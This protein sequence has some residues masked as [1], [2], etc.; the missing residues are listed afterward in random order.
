MGGKLK[1]WPGAASHRHLCWLLLKLRVSVLKSLSYDTISAIRPFR[2]NETPR[3]VEN[4]RLCLEGPGRG[5]TQLGSIKKNYLL[6]LI[7]I[8]LF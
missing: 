5:G 8:Y 6:I 3:Q 7:V 2:A 4:A 1:R